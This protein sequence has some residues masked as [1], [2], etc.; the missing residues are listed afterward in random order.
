LIGGRTQLHGDAGNDIIIVPDAEL[1]GDW[2]HVPI[3]AYG[4]GG[5]DLILG[6]GSALGGEGNDVF[7][8]HELPAFVM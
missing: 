5:D 1:N 7:V 4:G 6:S 3:R 8:C 2:E